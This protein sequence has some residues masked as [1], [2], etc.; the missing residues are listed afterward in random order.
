VRILAIETS[1]DHSSVALA[2]DG[3]VLA[4]RFFPSRMSLSQTLPG[5]IQSVL[6]AEQVSE[7]GLDA[8][9]VT[10]GPGSFTGLRVGIALAKAMAHALSL[11]LVGVGTHDLLAWPLLTGRPPCICV[12]QHARKM[13]VYSTTYRAADGALEPGDDCDVLSLDA[14]L[15]RLVAF[16]HEV[17]LVGDGAVRH[18]D[19]I[20]ERLGDRARFAPA[21]LSVPRAGVLAT[22]AEP[23][24]ATADPASAFTLRPTYALI[25]QA[26]R[27]HG[28]DLGM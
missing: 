13:D 17:T 7:A 4:E 27:A 25:S 24:V 14:L 26:E 15:E 20:R 19:A 23:L 11:P 1:G 9:A 3:M 18:G 6:E 5:H 22:L 12:M 28:V 8:I 16:E 21:L 2:H 10:L